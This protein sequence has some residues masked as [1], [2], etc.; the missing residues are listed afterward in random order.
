MSE[1]ST[2]SAPVHAVFAGILADAAS[3]PLQ[4]RRAQYVSRLARM[5]WDFEHS[6]DGAV[7]RRGREDLAMLRQL[8]R[9]LDPDHVLWQRHAPEWMWPTPP[10]HAF[11]DFTGPA[12]VTVEWLRTVHGARLLS[13]FVDTKERGACGITSVLSPKVLE[14][15]QRKV[16]HVAGGESIR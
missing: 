10:V 7:T 1:A 12:P 5:D 9:E 13:V 2:V 14:D 4:L 8:Q 6:D 3:I 15:L 16:E 11:Q